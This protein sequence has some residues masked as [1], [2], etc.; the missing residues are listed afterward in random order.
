MHRDRAPVVRDRPM[1]T[2]RS[3]PSPS[4]KAACAPVAVEAAATTKA[5][6]LALVPRVLEQEPAA[7]SL[8]CSRCLDPSRMGEHWL[9]GGG[10]Q[11]TASIRRTTLEA[12][13]QLRAVEVAADEHDPAARAARRPSTGR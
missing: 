8:M 9:G 12:A 7:V 1:S 10:R 3:V 11:L 13:A 2:S 6:S 5:S 4:A